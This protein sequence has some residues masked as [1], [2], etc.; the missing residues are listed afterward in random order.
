MDISSNLT[1]GVDN[2]TVPN[3]NAELNWWGAAS[4]P[5]VVGPGTGDNVTTNVD[6][7]PWCTNVACTT[8]G[9]PVVNITRS[10]YFTTIQAAID[11]AA[12]QNGDTITV[13]AGTFVE[14]VTINKSLTLTGVQ[15]DVPVSGRTAAGAGESTIHG[16]VIVSASNVEV[17]GFT[18]T[19][20]GQTYAVSISSS[21][22]TVAISYDMIEDVGA[23]GLGSNVHSIVFQ[24][25]ADNVSITHNSFNNI[26]ANAKTATGIG[27]LDSA[28]SNS[29][30]GLLIQ[31]NTFTN[32]AS[33]SKGAYGIIINNGAGTPNE[34]SVTTSAGQTVGDVI[35]AINTALGG[36][37][38]LTLNSD[39][40]VSQ[41]L[42]PSYSGYQLNVTGDTTARGTTGMS[43][44]QLFGIGDNQL[45]DRPRASA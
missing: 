12:T 17:N 33:V 30:T 42:A 29:S 14:N 43:F 15:A 18:L 34:A 24:N 4:G 11:D 23:V 39:G 10:T 6:Y 45:G 22:D 32:I 27:V 9:A 19:N 28:S 37:A 5:G 40:S 3:L 1:M 26:N 38:S 41:V 44:T 7:I 35:T 13:A 36:A 25:G 21:A 8:F 20:P 2:Q 31:D 16:L